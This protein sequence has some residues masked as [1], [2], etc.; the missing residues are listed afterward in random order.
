MTRLLCHCVGGCI[1]RCI[2]VDAMNAPEVVIYDCDQANGTDYHK[3]IQK[4]I[5]IMRG[6]D[7]I[8]NCAQT[9]VKG[10]RGVRPHEQPDPDQ[11]VHIIK[12]DADGIGLGGKP[13]KGVIVRGAKVCNSNAPYV[14][15]I[16]VLTSRLISAKDP[17]YAV[18]VA[19]PADWDGVKLASSKYLTIWSNTIDSPDQRC[20]YVG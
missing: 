18:A 7:L 5:L 20:F 10:I 1:Q 14:D 11:Y 8:A 13:Y 15:E 4:F 16:I 3:R 12:T 19:L 2:G 6:K 9:D 17:S